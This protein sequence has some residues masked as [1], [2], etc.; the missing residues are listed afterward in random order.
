M[1]PRHLKR[2]SLF[3]GFLFLFLSSCATGQVEKISSTHELPTD[4]PQE[5]QD[6]FKI[7]A[8]Q[9][10]IEASLSSSPVATP[11]EEKPLGKNKKKKKQ[12]VREQAKAV[13]VYPNRRPE[14][15]PFVVGEKLVYEVTYFG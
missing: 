6:K 8:A 12:A 11:V 9:T 4:L 15:E 10:P 1:L 2:S 14:K 3:I 5:L 7:E 13:F